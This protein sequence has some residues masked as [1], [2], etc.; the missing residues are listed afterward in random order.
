MPEQT[1]PRQFED[2][3]APTRIPQAVASVSPPVPDKP[4]AAEL[5]L[6][7]PHANA[8]YLRNPPPTYPKR[9]L[10]RGVEGSVLVRVQ[11]QDN[12]RCSQVLLKESDNI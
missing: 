2:Q 1:P 12:G 8:A 9:L 5:S 4:A 11:V 3:P 6:E 10:K 7:L